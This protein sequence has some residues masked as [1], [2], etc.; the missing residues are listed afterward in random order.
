MMGFATPLPGKLVPEG[1]PGVGGY[2]VLTFLASWVWWMGIARQVGPALPANALALFLLPGVFAPAIVAVWMTARAEGESGVR[3]LLGRVLRWQ[4]GARWYLFAFGYMVA[5]KLLA[6][7]AYRLISGTWP[8]FGADP[9]YLLLAA[10]VLSVPSQLGEEVG[11]RGY[12]LPRLASRLGLGFGSLVLGI[13]WATW[14]LPFFFYVESD[15]TGHPFLPYLLFVTAL[16]VAMAA[17]YWRTGGSLLLTM[18]MHAAINNTKDI[19]PSP[20]PKPG[21]PLLLHTPLVSWLTLAVL[22]TGAAVLL[23]WMFRDAQASRRKRP[24]G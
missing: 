23:V 5:A 16:S 11:W 2:F 10:T 1:A 13:V 8:V 7:S 20:V 15:K 18:V 3:L 17:L 9:W 24:N 22:W 14:H 12:A 19:V 6:A 4:V 21:E